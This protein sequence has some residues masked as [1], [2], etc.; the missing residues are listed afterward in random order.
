[1]TKLVLLV[2]HGESV[3]NVGLPTSIHSDIELTE[4]G[5]EQAKQ[6]ATQIDF[7]PDCILISNYKR[8]IDSS[9]P[10][11]Q[12]FPNA[13]YKIDSRVAEFHYLDFDNKP[14][15]PDDRKPRRD[16]YWSELNPDYNDG[17][18]CESFRQFIERVSN[19][20]QW[21]RFT[22]YQNIVVFTH[23]QFMKAVL[24]II[25]NCRPNY[26]PIVDNKFMERMHYQFDHVDIPNGTMIPIEF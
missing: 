14:T 24:Y 23:G 12:Q 20:I 4:K 22:D 15:T 7:V 9:L 11:K 8:A 13:V 21:A 18:D 16:R 19:F 5:K 3:A 25:I 17:P 2:R 1:M 26:S 10:T 6:I